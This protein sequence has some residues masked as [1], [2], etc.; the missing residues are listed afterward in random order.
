MLSKVT[1]RIE[2]EA[3][4]LDLTHSIVSIAQYHPSGDTCIC[5][6]ANH[7]NTTV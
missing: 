5:H 3:L 2:Q 1:K 7:N 4:H 6:L